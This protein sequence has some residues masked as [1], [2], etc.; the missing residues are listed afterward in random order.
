M[1]GASCSYSDTSTIHE[2]FRLH[3]W[4]RVKVVVLIHCVHYVN[5]ENI[6]KYNHGN[7]RDETGE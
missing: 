2:D 3:I 4:N 5:G 1:N 6:T 7:W